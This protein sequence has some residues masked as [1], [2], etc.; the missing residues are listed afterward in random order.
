MSNL[1][2]S[3]RSQVLAHASV[4]ECLHRTNTLLY[5]STNSKTFVTAFY[6]ALDLDRHEL[7]YANAG[8][9]PPLL[10]RASGKPERLERGGLVLGVVEDSKFQE[11]TCRMEPDD[12]T[13]I[14]LKRS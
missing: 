1:Q 4:T 13:L 9:N 2:A 7:R 8:H 3:I 5:R 12:I 10:F 14:V 6:C 11:A